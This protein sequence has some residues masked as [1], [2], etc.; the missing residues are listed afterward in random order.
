M[1]HRSQLRKAILCVHNNAVD[2][3]P[4]GKG[5]KAVSNWVVDDDVFAQAGLKNAHT[6]CLKN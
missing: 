6:L 5:L 2:Q 3:A 1:P 4:F